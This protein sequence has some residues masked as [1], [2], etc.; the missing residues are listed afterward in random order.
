MDKNDLIPF[1]TLPNWIR[2]AAACGFS[3]DPL[4]E[5]FGI[6]A[7]LI[8]LQEATI[9]IRAMD[10]L[11]QACVEACRQHSPDKHFPF[12]LGETFNFEY[13]PEIETYISTSENLREATHALR[14]V[15]ELV[16]P[17]VDLRLAEE[18]RLAWIYLSTESEYEIQTRSAIYYAESVQPT[19]LKFARHLLGSQSQVR[20]LRFRHPPPDYASMYE[21]YFHIP[22]AFNQ[23]YDG[24]EFDRELLDLPLQGAFPALHEQARY[25]VEQRV[26][27]QPQRKG[28]AARVQHLLQT[29]PELSTA[30]IEA[31]SQALRLHTRSLQRKLKDEGTHFGELVDEV[32]FRQAVVALQKNEHN[33]ERLSEKLGFADRRS[34]TRAFKRW[35]GLSPSQYRKTLG[36]H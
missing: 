1:V 22:V 2:A 34:F 36:T 9:E 20:I 16:N 10:G 11:M 25:L 8:H 26:A 35:S 21:D 13:L 6:Q 31:C 15:R 12:V 33:L 4:F 29:R 24:I 3:I 30:G 28:I 5:R 32:R 19:V 27:A 17:Y 14:W 18:G 23:P 7:D